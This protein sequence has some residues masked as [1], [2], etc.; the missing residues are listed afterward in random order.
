M[1]HARPNTLLFYYGY[2][3][4][5][6]SAVNQWNNENVAM[7]MA[8]YDV[9]VFG[10]G[11]QDPSH[12]DYSNTQ[13]ILARL[14]VLKPFI[15]IYG[16]VS[17]N[18]TI[19]DFETKVNQW[20]TLQI[21]GIFMDEAGYDFGVSR[22]TL[23]SQ[24]V[25]VRSKDYADRCF[26]NS[27]NMDHVIGIAEDVSYPNVTYNPSLHASLLDSRDIYLLESFAVNT[28]AYSGND[29]YA[30]QSDVSIRGE[31]AIAH[32]DTFGIQLATLG[33]ID[34]DS[35]TGQ[36]LFDFSYHSSL[37]FACD[38]EGTSSTNY[39]ASTAAINF[40]KRPGKKH[41]GRTDTVDVIQS[42][43]DTDVLERFGVN[44]KVILDFS[45]GAQISTIQNW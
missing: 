30:T 16:Y 27:W 6:N 17:S 1:A 25:H 15:K 28:T 18:Q 42:I 22:D 12:P 45:T 2:L 44:S 39:G 41:I 43:T 4:S 31:K 5:F 38:Y 11:V 19:S 37:L 32:R 10:D 21:D 3:N 8:K 34:D 14:K 9:C 40:W 7:D 36:Q 24:I 35:V 26:V 23:N 13:V 20:D 33:V 29:G